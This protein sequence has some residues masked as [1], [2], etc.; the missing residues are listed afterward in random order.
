MSD[1]R[2]R[3]VS[4]SSQMW[5]ADP[6]LRDEWRQNAKS[7]NRRLAVHA[8]VP[9]PEQSHSDSAGLDVSLVDDTADQL[10]Q[11]QHRFLAVGFDT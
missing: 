7:E 9:A 5:N 2:K 6:N 10:L 4:T 8:L 1:C 3:I 11:L